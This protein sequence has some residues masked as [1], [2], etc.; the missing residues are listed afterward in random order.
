MKRLLNCFAS[1][2]EKMTK[3]EL[4]LSIKASEGRII[5]SEATLVSEQSVLADVSDAE[6]KSSFGSE[7]ILFNWLDVFNPQIPCIDVENSEDA[8]LKVKKLTGRLL[9]ANLEPVD[10][11]AETMSEILPIAE[12]RK[13]NVKTAR[14]AVKIGLDYIL[15][16]GN[17]GTGVSNKAIIHAI[18]EIKEACGEELIIMAGK[19]HAAGSAIDIAEKIITKDLIKSFVDAGADVICLPAPGTVPGIS[20]EYARE[21]ISYTHT[22]GV[23][24]MTAIGTSQEGADRETIRQIALMCKMCGTDIHHIGDANISN[25]DNIMY[26]GYAIRGVRHTMISMAKSPLR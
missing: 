11:T 10:E 3:D 20:M 4:L 25:Y 13:A 23:L 6:M 16:T 18:K 15:L 12:G 5:C 7:L 19:M 17:P 1:D 21:L 22:L 2:L 9:G 24:T 8:I 26:Y 14:Q